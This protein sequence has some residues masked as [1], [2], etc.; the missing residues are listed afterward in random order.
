M[1]KP[2]K[3]ELMQ[4]LAHHKER[5]S[6]RDRLLGIHKKVEGSRVRYEPAEP[7]HPWMNLV[8]RDKRGKVLAQVSSVQNEDLSANHRLHLEPEV[9]AL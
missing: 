5:I 9:V 7:S 2:Y 4:I 8:L 6:F 1:M 3:K